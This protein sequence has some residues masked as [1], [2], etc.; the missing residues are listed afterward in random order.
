MPDSSTRDL[1]AAV[2]ARPVAGGAGAGRH[3]RREVLRSCRPRGKAAGEGSAGLA[4]EP[5]QQHL[6]GLVRGAA[7]GSGGSS[8]QSLL[9]G[10]RDLRS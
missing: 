6:L 7:K 8:L 2:P 3:R 9:A 5:R 10:C 1:Q 4:A